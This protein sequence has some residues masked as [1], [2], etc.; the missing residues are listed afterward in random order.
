MAVT[1]A[2]GSKATVVADNSSDGGSA[3]IASVVAAY[4][5]V[6]ISMVYLNKLLLSN[7]G[8]SIPA[9]LF[10]TW[11]QCLV[12]SIVCVLLG[13][14]GEKTRSSG[15]Q[16]HFNEYPLIKFNYATVQA[17]LPLSVA[18][19]GMVALNNVCLQLVEV[20]FCKFVRAC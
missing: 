6:S 12:T 14:I 18:F 5:V 15:Q 11:F 20:S 9:P 7:E 19:V 4:W 8:A 16:S 17:V 2:R 3:Y 1:A 13:Y 10:I